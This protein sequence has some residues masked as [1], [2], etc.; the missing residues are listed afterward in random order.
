MWLHGFPFAFQTSSR[1]PFYNY[2][3]EPHPSQSLRRNTSLHSHIEMKRK[4][5]R[6]KR[7]E[8]FAPSFWRDT[9]RCLEGSVYTCSYA[10]PPALW[11][12]SDDYIL[13]LPECGS[14]LELS[15]TL[16]WLVPS[17]GPAASLSNAFI[18]GKLVS[19]V[20]LCSFVSR[21]VVLNYSQLGSWQNSSTADRLCL[22]LCHAI[23]PPWTVHEGQFWPHLWTPAGS[24]VCFKVK[25]N[26]KIIK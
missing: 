9:C 11:W 16:Q 4:S 24:F 14:N 13:T 3:P 21:A 23:A 22:D 8:N 2:L 10:E 6:E 12:W 17:L 1:A 26:H 5:R 20:W 25:N 19:W 7:Y 15:L 18:F